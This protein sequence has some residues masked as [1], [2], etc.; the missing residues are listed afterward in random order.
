LQSG[1]KEEQTKKEAKKV[2][3]RAIPNE[4]AVDAW[5]AP[6]NQAVAV[7]QAAM[8][9][10]LDQHVGKPETTKKKS[11]KGLSVS[12]KSKGQKKTATIEA[13]YATRGSKTPKSGKTRATRIAE[14]YSNLDPRWAEVAWEKAKLWL[15]GKRKFITYKS[16]TDF[17]ADKIDIQCIDQDGFVGH[18]Q[19]WS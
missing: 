14:Q 4:R 19:T 9:E 17:R 3:V 11:G 12:G 5:Y 16:V 15:K 8:D 2:G 6:R 13:F 1:Y 7:F 10:Y 18:T